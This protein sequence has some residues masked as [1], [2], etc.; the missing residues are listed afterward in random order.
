MNSK[1]RLNLVFGLCAILLFSTVAFSRPAPIPSIIIRSVMVI[2]GT[3]SAPFGPTDVEIVEGKI[4][5]IGVNLKSAA[6]TEISGAGKTL[7]PGLI[8]CHTHVRSV[9]GA[10][11]R[12][13]TSDKIK[14]QQRV[15]LRAYLAA[16]VTTVLDAATPTALY[17]EISEIS[18]DSPIPRFLG[19]SP[20]LTPKNGYFAG[21]QA[22]R[23]FYND[24]TQPIEAESEIAARI[25]ESI[26]HR[27]LGI[28]TTVEFGFSP[29]AAYPVFEESYID[30]IR[31]ESGKARLPIFA[32]SES[33]KAFRI[34]LK[35]KPYAFM[36]GGFFD[37]PASAEIVREIKDS[38]A[39]V[40]STLAIYKLMLL[41]WDQKVFE[42]P[43]LKILV[44]AEQIQ[45]AKGATSEVVRLLAIQNKP[46][47]VP[48]FVAGLLASQFINS[49]T[50]QKNF[51]N[52][53]DSIAMMH[54]SGVPIVMGSDSGN[55]PLFSTFF[56]G[57]GSILEI[58]ALEEAGL[59]MLDA[60]K[61]STSV[62]AKM[63]KIENEVGTVSVG[64]AADLI[65]LNQDPTEFPL[66]FRDVE[67]VIKGGDARRPVDWM[68]ATK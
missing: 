15:Q 28:K 29:F 11:F 58:E 1:L 68:L 26:S 32:H 61:A 45:T 60:I 43:W 21:E 13:D 52:S 64:K 24:L 10:V 12:G 46:W 18:K 3:G 9:P 14:A 36:H 8:D 41:M 7:T 56:H 47:F 66:A 23:E 57:V 17:N 39:Y 6:K 49:K 16:G 38:G 44:P 34:A 59:P 63:L 40:V 54:R 35:L 42:E 4:S 31:T 2:D 65:L 48:E 62:A 19:L 67:Y 37:K 22:R 20:F 25:A 53:R 50:I 51:E 5:R 33:E 55:Y 30:R 27:P